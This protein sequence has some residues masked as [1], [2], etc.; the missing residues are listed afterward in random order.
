VTEVPDPDELEERRDK[1]FSRRVA[2]TTAIYAIILAIASLGGNNAMEDILLAQQEATNQWAYYQAKVI[3]EHLNRGSKM[4]VETQLAEPSPL[5]GAERAKFE[6]LATRYAD[7]EKRMNADKK[8]IERDARKFEAARDLSKTRDVYFDLAEVF[9]QIAI[10]SSSVAI[11]GGSRPMF[12]FSL[13]L[14]IVGTLATVNGFLLFVR[15]A[16]LE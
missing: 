11:L 14:A 9:L 1:T 16:V 13:A 12:W 15:V 10:V 3:R 7:E 8:A 4:L 6:A 2:L 5:K